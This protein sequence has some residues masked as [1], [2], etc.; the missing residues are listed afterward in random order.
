MCNCSLFFVKADGGLPQNISD[1]AF[2][3]ILIKINRFDPLKTFL[4]F[5]RKYN[6][7]FLFL[8]LEAM[9][10]VLLFR[11]NSFQGSVWFTAAN[12]TVAT[13]NRIYYDALAYL[14]LGNVNGQLTHQNT[15]LSQENAYLRDRLGELT[16]Q[17]TPTELSIRQTLVG[18]RLLDAVVVSNST[19]RANNYLVI[20]RGSLDGVRP[21]MGI[22]GGGGAVGIV[23]L[24]GPHYSL[25]IPITNRKSSI[26][27]RVRG[28]GYFG[29]LQWSGRNLLHAFVNDIPRYAKIKKGAIIETSGYSAVFPPGIFIGRVNSVGNSP[30]GQSYQLDITL[31]T[32]FS[33][34]RNVCVVMTPYKAEIDTLQAHAAQQD[35]HDALNGLDTIQ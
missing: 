19:K 31:G 3:R 35:I 26:S 18:Y 32:D 7:F 16:H 29:Y 15:L 13:I 6:Y 33:K 8:L 9:S 17:A 23:Y 28:Q 27:C 10:F 1:A 24:T 12:S 4:D 22:V 11:F 14:Q 5:L 30:D 2:P 34:L 21:E 20:N 25:V